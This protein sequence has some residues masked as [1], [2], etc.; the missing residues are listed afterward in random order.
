MS[1]ATVTPHPRLAVVASE[2]RK[3]ARAQ[4]REKN[5]LRKVARGFAV[6]F[7]ILFATLGL[8]AGTAQAWPWSNMQE[9]ITAFVTNFCGPE[10]VPMPRG[11]QGWDTLFGLN[12]GDSDIRGTVR[13]DTAGLAES[14][15][16]GLDRIQQ[17]YGAQYDTIKPTYE[18]YG[19][20]TLQWDSYGAGCFSQ[21]YWFTGVANLMLNYFVMFP[22]MVAMATLKLALGNI[23][24]TIFTGVISPFVSIFTAIFKGWALWLA[25]IG[26][27]WAFLRSG[28]NLRVVAKTGAWMLMILGVFLWMGNN[29]STVVTKA[30]NFVTEFAGTAATQMNEINGVRTGEGGTAVDSI[31]QS[32]WYGVPYQTW[33]EGTVGP[34]TAAGDRT[35][36]ANGEVSWG[37]VLLNAKYVG[38]DDAG[39]DVIANINKWNG[40][41]YSPNE[42]LADEAWGDMKTK[43]G[44]WTKN[45]IW[46]KIPYLFNVKAMCA[47]TSNGV[48]FT[49]SSGAED[50]KW[51]YGGS[52]DSASAGTSAMIPYF[53]GTAYN[54]RLATAFSGGFAAMA[55]T[56]AVAAAA[57]Y[58]MVQ[59][60]LFYFLLLFG[61]VFLTVA[62][63]GDEKRAAFAK[64]YGELMIANILKQGVAVLVVLFVANAMS[65]LLYPPADEQFSALR[66]IPWM[67]KPSLALL[68]LIGLALFL[69]PLKRIVTGAVKGDTKAVDKTA[70]MPIDA[71]KTTAKVAGGA[72][73]GAAAIAAVAATGGAAAPVVGK[74]GGMAMSAGRMAGARGGVG[75]VL[76]TAGRGANLA[77]RVGGGIADSQG[78]KAALGNL[79]KGV[80]SQD[81]KAKDMLGK[82]PGA[83][84]KDGKMT[85][86]GQAIMANAIKKTGKQGEQSARADALQKSYMDK[87]YKGHLAQTGKHHA[88]DPNSPDNLRAAAIAKEQERMSVKESAKDGSSRAQNMA[89]ANGTT[90]GPD[91]T[92]GSNA[93]D[94]PNGGTEVNR[95]RS[96]EQSAEAVRENIS[97]PD[98]AEDQ[99]I[100]ANVTVEGAQIAE[101]MGMSAREVSQNPAALLTGTAYE[102][103]DVTKMDP[104]HPATSAMNDLR[105]AMTTGDEQGI[106]SASLRA[107][108]AISQHGVP[109]Q[110]AG[111]SAVSGTPEGMATVV[112]AMP[113]ISDD[114]PWQVRAEGATT[115][116]AAMA[117][118]PESSPAYEPMQNYVQALSTPS[119]D[120]QT[121]EGMR[122]LV[123]ES[124]APEV[125]AEAPPVDVSSAI[126]ESAEQVSAAPAAVVAEQGVLFGEAPA[127]APAQ[128][129]AYTSAAPSFAQAEAPA[130]YESGPA[131]AS[132]DPGPVPASHEPG[133]APASH[134]S[135]P[136]PASH[137]PGSAPAAHEAGPAPA[138]Y[139]ATSAPSA[140]EPGPAPAS[141]ESGPAPVSHESAPA[142]ASHEPGPAPAHE[143]PARETP[144]YEEGPVNEAP[145]QAAPVYRSPEPSSGDSFQSEAPARFS[146]FEGRVYEGLSPEA[147][148][149]MPV[150]PIPSASG[151]QVSAEMDLDRVRR[152]LS[153]ISEEAA[154]KYRQKMT[155][156][157][158]NFNIPEP[159]LS[160]P[161]GGGA[162]DSGRPSM[163]GGIDLGKAP[164]DDVEEIS[165]M[166][167]EDGDD[168]SQSFRRSRR[169][170]VS[171]F[172]DME[173]E[174]ESDKKDGE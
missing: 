19:F 147:A 156:W 157:R 94:A 108:E 49:S 109:G 85:P 16:N 28:G 150:P 120:A 146:D 133:P 45:K 88:M 21:G 172:F 75:K 20:S 122:S 103:G 65:M 162:E 18:R 59:K 165:G 14:P 82:I 121:V 119:V 118:V 159:T 5:P 50:N 77:A 79:A 129:P 68:F 22:M 41:S 93:P 1:V 140:H 30:N 46:E 23:L 33:L 135:A 106:Q 141:Y 73:V 78:K 142:P 12:L 64:R 72:A 81:P 13:P 155:E 9:D 154:D 60:M 136:A 76:T 166:P 123:I 7:A 57:I 92:S 131:P 102:G 99:N 80:F 39:R 54:A 66:E 52:C 84:D 173:D 101:Q 6:A 83:L 149:A 69:L 31:N 116:Q 126:R 63:F 47:D 90:N 130:S 138:S 86:K 105:F 117:M 40:L 53:T 3:E 34:S 167:T 158:D 134:E 110:I 27:V 100:K 11:H 2:A 145:A 58:L 17:A 163:F 48:V 29:T 151:G 127:E 38:N 132:H 4:K 170:R 74:L 124:V 61:P 168:N 70:N 87:F 55:V 125:A 44:A 35:R 152:E 67:L 97:G 113:T 112:N 153:E 164:A 24:Y 91:A 139:E 114:T 144:A 107:S 26:I 8:G 56:L 111:V 143:A 62:M 89:G 43:P 71:A 148:S 32:L 15:L 96:R 115:M 160:S 104:R 128:A 95:E 98:F 25:P 169:R 37:A 161:S 51:M 174:D 171:G 42:S 36:E 10:D 137:E